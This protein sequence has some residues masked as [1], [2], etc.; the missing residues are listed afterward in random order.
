M[1]FTASGFL[2]RR[3]QLSLTFC[4][5][6][7]HW[8]S[9]HL[10]YFATMLH[11]TF[12]RSQTFGVPSF[13]GE[14]DRRAIKIAILAIVSY[15]LHWVVKCIL[16]SDDYQHFT[17]VFH[18]IRSDNWM[19]VRFSNTRTYCWFAVVPLSG[20]NSQK[21][22]TPVGFFHS[23][24]KALLTCD[25]HSLCSISAISALHIS[26]PYPASINFYF[27]YQNRSFW[28]IVFFSLWRTHKFAMFS[29]ITHGWLRQRSFFVL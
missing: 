2:S 15:F 14:Y 23:N 27:L 21:N 25:A 3:S 20:S 9:I 7:C 13:V 16:C 1:T 19:I 28:C 24:N 29:R 5:V 26:F 10:F 18:S 8:R 17:K 12:S 6:L 4:L 22:L 11:C